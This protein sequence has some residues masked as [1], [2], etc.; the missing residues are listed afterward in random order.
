MLQLITTLA[1][2]EIHTGSSVSVIK[3]VYP[4]V[5]E[6]LQPKI[7]QENLSFSFDSTAKSTVG[8]ALPKGNSAGS[9]GNTEELWWILKDIT[10]SHYILVHIHKINSVGEEYTSLIPRAPYNKGRDPGA[11]SQQA[12]QPELSFLRELALHPPH[13]THARPGGLMEQLYYHTLTATSSHARRA[14][15]F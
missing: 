15:K 12:F 14:I 11:A 2:S 5:D 7:W 10:V 1:F 4:W 8:L 13:C 6:L 3:D 9:A